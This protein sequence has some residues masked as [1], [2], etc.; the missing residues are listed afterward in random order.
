M[1]T[2]HERKQRPSP[3]RVGLDGPRE[4]ERPSFDGM[5]SAEVQSDY[6]GS[7]CR[8]SLLSQETA[9]AS[10][11][12]SVFDELLRFPWRYLLLVHTRSLRDMI[13][14]VRYIYTCR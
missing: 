12:I 2:D 11:P 3:G 7:V 9:C 14:K 10:Y 4:S 1:S 8:A 5:Q 6:S 13:Y